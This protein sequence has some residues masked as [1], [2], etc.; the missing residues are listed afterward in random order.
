MVEMT[1]ATAMSCTVCTTS[2]TPTVCSRASSM[3]SG[4]TCSGL[5]GRL[6]REHR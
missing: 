2:S 4:S 6:H 5:F 1:L 3:N